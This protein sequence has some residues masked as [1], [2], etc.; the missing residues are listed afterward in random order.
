MYLQSMCQT[1]SV[2]VLDRRRRRNVG[3]MLARRRPNIAPT[4]LERLAFQQEIYI[5][6]VMGLT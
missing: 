3:A 2:N 5:I 4:L 6:I 1:V